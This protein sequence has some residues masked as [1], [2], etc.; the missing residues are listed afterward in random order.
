M[1]GEQRTRASEVAMGKNL[2]RGG[3]KE[4]SSVDFIGRGRCGEKRND[5]HH[6]SHQWC[7]TPSNDEEEMENGKREKRPA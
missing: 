4:R 6:Y 2:D 3:R 1:S 7:I 5:S